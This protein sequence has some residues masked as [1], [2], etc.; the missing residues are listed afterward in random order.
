MKQPRLGWILYDESCGLSRRWISAW[1]GTL[2]RRGFDFV[3]L[4]TG[5]VRDTLQLDESELLRDIRLLLID[6]SRISGADVYR[7]AMRRIWWAWPAY[8]LSITL[9]LRRIF[10]WC[11]HA[12]AANR[13]RISSA[14]GMDAP[15]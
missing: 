6:G 7:F 5:W 10:D 14:C 13:F 12:I 8:L 1:E 15:R 4:Q 11:Y 2:R 9:G 3:P